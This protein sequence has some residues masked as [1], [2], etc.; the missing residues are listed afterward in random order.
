MSVP[1]GVRQFWSCGAA[2]HEHA[3]V[4]EA[5]ACLEQR[6]GAKSEEQRKEYVNRRLYAGTSPPES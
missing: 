1:E 4:Q 5:V 3:T 2:G 6:T